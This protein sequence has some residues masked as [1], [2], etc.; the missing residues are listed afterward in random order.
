MGKGFRIFTTQR[1]RGRVNGVAAAKVRVQEQ[2]RN[3][4]GNRKVI[5]GNRTKVHRKP[6]VHPRKP[7]AFS[8]ETGSAS[9]EP[10]E[11]LP[12]PE[13]KITGTGSGPITVPVNLMRLPG[14]RT[15]L[16]TE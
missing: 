8:P 1:P 12:E 13:Q 2:A 14:L 15:H 6:E 11:I 5:P 3:V 4:T 7:E 10:E 9:P 16:L